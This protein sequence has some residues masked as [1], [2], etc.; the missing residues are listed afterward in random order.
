[1]YFKFERRITDAKDPQNAEGAFIQGFHKYYNQK[2]GKH[3]NCF[4]SVTAHL[5]CDRPL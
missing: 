1:V 5:R 3:Q 2:L 4:S